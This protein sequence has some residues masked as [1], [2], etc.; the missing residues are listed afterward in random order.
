MILTGADPAFSAGVDLKEFGSGAG[1]PRR[2]DSADMG[3]RDDDGRLPFRGAL[4]PRTKPLIGAINGVAVTGGLRG[5]AQL[6]LPRRVGPRALRRHARA[7]R[8]DARLGSHGAARRSASAWR[9]P[10]E[11][12][13]TGNYVDARDRARVGPGQPRRAARG[14]AAVL[15]GS[16]RPTS[17]RTTRWACAACS[18]PTTRARSTTVDDGVG[19]RG[20]RE[21]RVGGSRLRP[22]VASRPAARRSS[23]AAAPSNRPEPACALPEQLSDAGSTRLTRR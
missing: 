4:P 7:R 10:S 19:D 20:P 2:G 18:R 13:V 6:R 15:R 12:S 21:P 5:R 1:A 16:S 17:S 22:R 3:S 14:A 23:T 8:R 11:M 9:A